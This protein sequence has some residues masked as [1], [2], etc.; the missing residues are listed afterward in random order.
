MEW[1]DYEE[2]Y[3]VKHLDYSNKYGIGFTLSTDAV[4]VY[5]N[6]KTKMVFSSDLFHFTY[7]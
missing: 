6:D 3:I 5:F 1:D 7:I 4:G 2:P